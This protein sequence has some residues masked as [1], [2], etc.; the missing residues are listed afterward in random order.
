MIDNEDTIEG[1]WRMA[2]ACDVELHMEY[3]ED[4]LA[5]K[6]WHMCTLLDGNI[7]GPGYHYCISHQVKE[8]PYKLIMKDITAFND[9]NESL[10]NELPSHQGIIDNQ[11]AQIAELKLISKTLKRKKLSNVAEMMN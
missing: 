6:T 10:T 2:R 5:D 1:E 7:G 3:V 4:V 11:F 9:V 8:L